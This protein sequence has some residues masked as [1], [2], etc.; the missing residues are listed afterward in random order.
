MLL[1]VLPW[2][3]GVLPSVSGGGVCAQGDAT[4][5]AA[6][7]PQVRG[8]A[9]MWERQCYQP[10]AT[11]LSVLTAMLWC[12][13]ELRSCDSVPAQSGLLQRW[14]AGS[15]CRGRRSS[16]KRWSTMVTR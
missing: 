1:T 12:W 8:G 7:L 5:V 3:D 4:M 2:R 9:V 11:V 10:S 14:A 16:G 15:G 6:V 13:P